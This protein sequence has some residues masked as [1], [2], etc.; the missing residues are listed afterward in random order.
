MENKLTRMLDFKEIEYALVEN[1]RPA[2]S[3]EQISKER[4]IGLENVLKCILLTDGKKYCLA[5][6]TAD[7][8]LDLKKIRNF[9][10]A[11]RLSFATKEEIKLVTGYRSGCVNPIIIK[12]KVSIIFDHSVREKKIVDISAG[13]PTAGI[14][15]KQQHLSLLVNPRFEGITKEITL[16]SQVK[17]LVLKK[18][19]KKSRS[20][21]RMSEKE[22]GSESKKN[23]FYGNN[24]RLINFKKNQSGL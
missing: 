23:T 6:T 21:Q 1:K 24:D 5:C 15:I 4:N 3:G 18:R 10:K 11:D 22:T 7:T 16:P 2:F 17:T 13:I 9:L 14:Q 20:S 12:K 19:G 8:Q